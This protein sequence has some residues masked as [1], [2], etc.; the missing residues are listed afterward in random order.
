M[1]SWLTKNGRI[2]MTQR[3]WDDHA[4]WVCHRVSQNSVDMI[5]KLFKDSYPEVP[6][7]NGGAN[8]G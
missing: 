7:E 4:A 8:D 2:E 3:E 5:V 1:P 6:K